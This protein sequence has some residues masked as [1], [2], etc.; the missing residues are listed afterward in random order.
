M[1]IELQGN[2]LKSAFM[3]GMKRS[4]NWESG[5][6]QTAEAAMR[7]R[8]AVASATQLKEAAAAAA[9]A[10]RG[11]VS[12][13]A[14]YV[15][16][17]ADPVAARAE[18][19]DIEISKLRRNKLTPGTAPIPQLR[20]SAVVYEAPLPG[21]RKGRAAGPAAK[22]ARNTSANDSDGGMVELEEDDL[23]ASTAAEEVM[24]AGQDPQ[25]SASGGNRNGRSS[26]FNQT[27]SSAD[28]TRQR[29]LEARKSAAVPM[30]RGTGTGVK[31]PEFLAAPLRHREQAQQPQQEDEAEHEKHQGEESEAARKIRQ[32]AIAAARRGLTGPS[33]PSSSSGL[34]AG[35]RQASRAPAGLA[36]SKS[37]APSKGKSKPQ[38]PAS[39]FA[40]AFGS[41]IA[42]MEAAHASDSAIHGS[43]YKDAVA[44]ADADQ[45]FATMEVLERKDDLAQ[46][47]DSVK[48]L[49]VT[50]WRCGACGCTTEYRPKAC[51]E[52]HPR[53]LTQIQAVKRWWECNGCKGRF[54]TVGLRYPNKRCPKCDVPGTDFTAVSMLRPQR[55]LEHQVQQGKVAGRE[56]LLVRGTE[57]KWINQ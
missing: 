44:D 33:A 21:K 31:V 53:E 30:G 22:R 4:L 48:T 9:K 35:S 32:A 29:A 41:V 26:L 18:V 46:K 15:K 6:F 34:N 23:F 5:K 19:Q 50:A 55:Q 47:M 45:L 40:A 57:Q 56:G 17:V 54:C 28:A 52:A 12:S 37:L 38:A 13:G 49:K 20:T 42:E 27:N 10:G 16:T 7:P 36:G 11:S 39:G 43:L 3:P 51:G 8:M 14:R 2:Q 25:G 24:G 1:R